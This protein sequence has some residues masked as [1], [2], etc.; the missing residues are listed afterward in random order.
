MGCLSLDGVREWSKNPVLAEKLLWGRYF[1]TS[2]TIWSLK[3]WC[4]ANSKIEEL[5]CCILVSGPCAK[6]GNFQDG[7]LHGIKPCGM[8]ASCA[9][10]GTMLEK[11]AVLSRTEF[12]NVIQSAQIDICHR[13]TFQ[14]QMLQYPD[15]LD[16]L[17]STVE[18]AK[19]CV[20]SDYPDEQICYE[21]CAMLILITTTH[22]CYEAVFPYHGIC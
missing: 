18:S 3:F 20:T 14:M 12:F 19:E 15:T 8:A 16:I 21:C 7:C 9:I 22:Q 1:A 10:A 13:C 11:Y 6:F 2:V 5:P 17:M 4:D